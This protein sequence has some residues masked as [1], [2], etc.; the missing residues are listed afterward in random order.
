MGRSVEIIRSAS[1]G[2]G[3]NSRD[4]GALLADDSCGSGQSGTGRNATNAIFA[5]R[6][7]ILM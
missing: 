3:G 5:L 7:F 4:D 6:P 1:S 2:G